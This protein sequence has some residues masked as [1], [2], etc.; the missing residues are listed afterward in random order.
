MKLTPTRPPGRPNR[1]ALCY[2]AEIIRLRREG[3]TCEAIRRALLDA[4]LAVSLATVKRE[5]SRQSK[6]STST[7]SAAKLTPTLPP[8]EIAGA[9]SS[10]TLP[11][12]DDPRSSKE[13][14]AAFVAGRTTNPLLR[15]RFAP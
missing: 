4:G 8:R 14:A 11:F 3:Y 15:S 9:P 2:A 10:A 1:K 7:F 6:P 12:A 5:A 13:I